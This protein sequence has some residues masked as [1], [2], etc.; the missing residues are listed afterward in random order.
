VDAL[1]DPPIYRFSVRAAESRHQALK[2]LALRAN[3]TPQQLVQSLFDC[4]DLTGADGKVRL[5]LEHFHKLFPADETTKELAARAASVG[6]T[7]RELKVFRAVAAA[8]GIVGIVR[9]E[10]MDIAARSGV[11]PALHDQIYDRLLEKGFLAAASGRGLRSFR[12]CRMPD[13]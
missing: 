9:P 8:A 11:A 7:A 5:A 10:P 13:I 6:L 3:M 4:I 1:F 2:E 12:I